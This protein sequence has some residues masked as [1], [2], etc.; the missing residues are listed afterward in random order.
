[1]TAILGVSAFYHDSAAALLVDGRIVAA[2]QEERFTRKKHDHGFPANAIDFCLAEAGLTPADLDYVGFYDKPLLKF[3]RLLET[4]LA[5]APRGFA[6]FLNALPLW[7][8]Q[9]LHLPRELSAGLHGAYRKKFVFTEHHEAHAASAFFPSP[10]DEAAI[11]TLDGVGEW[12]TASF[13]VGRGNRIELTHEL[14]FPHS[15]GLLYSA[16]T[17]FTGFRVNSGEYKLMGLAPYGTPRFAKV[18][19][20]TLLDLKDDGSFRM[21]MSY[22]NYCQGMT[23]TSPKFDTL[24][25]GPPRRAE[26]PV[27]QREMDIAASI[28]EVTEDIML[29]CARHVHATTGMKRLC[30]A[31]GVALNCVGNGK[32]LRNGP[33]ED[34]WIQPAAGDAGGALGV[35][36]F[37]SH[38]LL[39]TPRRPNGQDTQSGSLLGPR[40]TTDDIRAFLDSVGATARAFTDDADLC[41]FVASLIAQEKVVGWFQGRMEFGPRALG[42]RSIIGDPRSPSMQSTM[43][44]KVKFRESFRPFAPSVLQE[45]VHEYFQMRQGQDSP[46]M[47]LV[48]PLHEVQRLGDAD[49]G[50]HLV[51]IEKLQVPRSTIPAVTHVD[52]SVRVQTVDAE[53]HGRYFRLLQAFE[54]QTGCPVLINTSFNVRG[55]PIVCRPSEAHRCFLATNMDVL[56]LENFVL[57]RE[58]QAQARP[59]D[60]SAH[61]AQFELD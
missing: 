20:E 60:A 17:F 19:R 3:E 57:L 29:R 9:K 54:R 50:A 22:F 35:A 49:A 33:F 42:C 39:D 45:H 16:F 53:R 31:G 37:I 56:V 27:T 30:L 52:Y 46:Y 43:N 15:I 6:S 34:I 13:G 24:F 38:Q 58:E 21:D 8:R 36:L 14:H 23:M 11:L 41:E 44:L 48:A 51:G 4:Y 1:M 26:S 10:F 32:I 25:E 12:A 55:E 40:H 2:A 18:I 5:F 61:L 7:F 59:V 47:L 28:Q